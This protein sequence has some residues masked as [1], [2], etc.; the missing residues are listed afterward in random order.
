MLRMN[1]VIQFLTF[2]PVAKRF[3]VLNSLQMAA[4]LFP[5]VYIVTPFTALLPTAATQQIAITSIM[6]L[7]A[8]AGTFAF[9]CSTILLTNSATSLRLL[10]T[11]NGI[12]VSCS[13]LGRAAGPAIGG[14]TYTLGVEI[15]YGVLPWWILA[16]LAIAAA[17]PIWWL[18]EMEGFGSDSSMEDDENVENANNDTEVDYRDQTQPLLNQAIREDSLMDETA[19]FNPQAMSKAVSHSSTGSKRGIARRTSNPIGMKET[20][21]TGGERLSSS[22]GQ[23][24]SGY[25]TYGSM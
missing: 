9:P 4:I 17:V 18:V 3:G 15:G 12:A 13:A 24:Q 11:L 16:L 7:K 8:W 20:I 14:G 25:G 5:I 22:L 1:E 6:L 19:L 23:T 10:A 21:G 2:P